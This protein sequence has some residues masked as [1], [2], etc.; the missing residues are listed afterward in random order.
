MGFSQGW[1]WG[2]WGVEGCIWSEQ[3]KAVCVPGL[4]SWGWM[5]LTVSVLVSMGVGLGMLGEAVTSA[6]LARMLL[7]VRIWDLGYSAGI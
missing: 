1:I 5:L 7:S 4:E 6:I 3:R 2:S